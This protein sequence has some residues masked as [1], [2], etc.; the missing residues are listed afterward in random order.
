MDLVRQ[1]KTCYLPPASSG[2]LSRWSIVLS[3]L[4]CQLWVSLPLLP[5]PLLYLELQPPGVLSSVLFLA[6]STTA[7]EWVYPFHDVSYQGYLLKLSVPARHRL[8]L[9]SWV[10]VTP[11]PT[12]SVKCCSMCTMVVVWVTSSHEFDAASNTEASFSLGSYCSRSY[13]F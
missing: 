11:M 10:F 5:V 8:S 7:K 6:C 12:Y 3:L 13:D 4:L 1:F 2:S 9:S